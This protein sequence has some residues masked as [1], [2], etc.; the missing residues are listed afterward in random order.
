M[1]RRARW[2]I[3]LAMVAMFVCGAWYG[4]DAGRARQARRLLRTPPAP[5]LY[6]GLCGHCGHQIPTGTGI[7]ADVAI[8]ADLRDVFAGWRYLHL[9]LCDACREVRVGSAT[10]SYRPV[11]DERG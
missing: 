7:Q 11:P 5:S 8:P 1:I 9:S 2:E 4:R 10:F 6:A 3:A